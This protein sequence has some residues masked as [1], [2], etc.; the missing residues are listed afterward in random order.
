MQV[1]IFQKIRNLTTLKTF[2][3]VYF[4]YN[5]QIIK[6]SFWD[7]GTF[8]HKEDYLMQVSLYSGFIFKRSNNTSVKNVQK[9]FISYLSQ[10]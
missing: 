7:F 3:Q 4:S 10:R 5:H 9:A 2:R 6:R 1:L 8:S